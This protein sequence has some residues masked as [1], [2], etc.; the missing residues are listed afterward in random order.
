MPRIYFTFKSVPQDENLKRNLNLKKNFHPDSG[1]IQIIFI[2]INI[3]VQPD[4]TG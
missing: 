1:S 3:W 2:R 4:Q